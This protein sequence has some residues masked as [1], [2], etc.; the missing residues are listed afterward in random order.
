M[1]SAGR[2]FN[3]CDPTH[4]TQ[5]HEWPTRVTALTSGD[6]FAIEGI[7]EKEGGGRER[8]GR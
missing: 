8:E 4:E 5:F 2:G 3:L 6:R 7:D 1:V